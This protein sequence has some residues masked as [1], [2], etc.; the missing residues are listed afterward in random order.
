MILSG[1]LK[2]SFVYTETG[3]VCIAPL[4]AE[5]GA[6]IRPSMAMRPFFGIQPALM[7][8]K[9]FL[10]I[11]SLICYRFNALVIGSVGCVSFVDT[12]HKSDLDFKSV[13]TPD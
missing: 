9:V 6:E 1:S 8:D 4:P 7:G 5:P 13:L 11:K 3:G 10:F 12:E 2:S